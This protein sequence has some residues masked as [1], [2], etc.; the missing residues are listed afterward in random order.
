MKTNDRYNGYSNHETGTVRE[1]ASKGSSH[2]VMLT[3]FERSPRLAEIRPV[4]KS[5]RKAGE[6]KEIRHSKDVETYLRAVW[7]RGTL[8]L[9][10]DFVMIC[11]NGSYEAIGWVKISSGGFNAAL[12]DPRLIFAVALQTASTAIILAHNHPSGNT[13]PSE[14]DKAITRQLREAGKLL[15]IAVLDHL[16]LT[17]EAFFSFAEN[18]LL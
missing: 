3:Q 7:N 13:E 9:V 16:I 11:L 12:V 1:N 8:E 5:R 2:P 17:K 6:K 4:Y 14:N 10:E 15:S 18:G